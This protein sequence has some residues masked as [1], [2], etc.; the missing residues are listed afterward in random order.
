M[1]L[2]ALVSACCCCCC[3]CWCHCRFRH[4]VHVCCRGPPRPP[5]LSAA[6]NDFLDHCFKVRVQ[7]GVLVQ[8]LETVS[9]SRQ[10]V[11]AYCRPATAEL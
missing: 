3:C 5:G 7:H 4:D 2:T 9:D 11:T 1:L 10:C 6:A 8:G